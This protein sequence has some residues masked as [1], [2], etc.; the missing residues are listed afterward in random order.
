MIPLKQFLQRVV[1][2]CLAIGC[3]ATAGMAHAAACNTDQPIRLGGL[4][5]E[6]GQITTGVLE[7]ILRDGYGC[8]TEV[9]PGSPT[10]LESALL[11]DDI[12][13]IAEQWMGRSEP[14]EK[15][16]AEGRANIVGDTLKG[17]AEQGWYVPDYVKEAHPDL[18][19]VDDLPRFAHLFPNPEQPGKARLMNCPPG[20][21]CE[22]FNTS[23]LKNTGL[24][25]TFSSAQPG[26]GA[27]LDAEISAAFEQKKPILFYYWQP[28]GLMAKYRMER[29]ALPPFDGE[30]WRNLLQ[31]DKNTRCVSDFPVSKLAVAVSSQF[32]KQHPELIA[33]LKKLQ[34]EPD[35]LNRMI[36]DMTESRRSGAQQA[37]RFMRERPEIWGKWVSDEA[38]SRLEK[39]FGENAVPRKK[40]GFFPEWSVAETLNQVLA[41]T[42]RQYG[43]QFRAL[44]QAMLDGFLLPLEQGLMKLPP[45]LLLVL[46]AAIAW[47]A[48][49]VW[50]QA[51]ACAAGFYLIGALG[52][53]GAL[54]QTLALLI[55]SSLFIIVLGFPLGVLMARSDRLH[56]WFTPV[57]DIIQTMPSFV[58]LIPV[59]MLFGIGKVPA[60]FATV[61]YAIAPLIRLTA[62]GIRQVDRRLTEAARSFGST[63]W[64]IL[65]WVQL[66]QAR[67]SIMAGINQAVMMSLGMV[68]VAS[69]IGARG[70]GES[71][72]QAIQTLNIGQGVQAGT[73]IVILAIVIDR[74]TQAYGRA[75]QR[76]E[77]K[78]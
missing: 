63:H 61:V 36:L 16:V 1:A 14:L 52:L 57:L 34:F 75:G 22:V 23:L 20:W 39:K 21:A 77:G 33:V 73:A 68:V 71:V 38:R 37:E 43:D 67:P 42:V 27:A 10:T 74:I 41:T 24:S 47:H 29:I 53:W 12:Q 13:I 65:F 76:K 46:L 51:L 62:L 15:A 48:T 44:S 50:W 64:Q 18:K 32:E 58:Y 5:W 78:A 3:L 25:E 56:R 8:K 17:G 54:M 55:A 35:M 69:M 26:T 45:W 9:V 66:P 31:G 70:L 60:L 4:D 72:L 7:S 40:G 49:R 11:Q 28:S 6:S 19:R 2:I 59:L 30:C